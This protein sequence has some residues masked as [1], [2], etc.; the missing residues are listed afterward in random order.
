MSELEQASHLEAYDALLQWEE[1]GLEQLLVEEIHHIIST[2]YWHQ[3]QDLVALGLMHEMLMEMNVLCSVSAPTAP[4][5]H[6][7][8]AVLTS[9]IS[10]C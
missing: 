7:I 10:I 5:A 6:L 3:L 4:P 9:K 8:H 1:S 2:V